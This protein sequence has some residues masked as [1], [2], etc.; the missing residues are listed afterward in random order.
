MTA[1]LSLTA[2]TA[3]CVFAIAGCDQD[4]DHQHT[5]TGSAHTQDTAE[6]SQAPTTEAFYEGQ[7]EPELI[8]APADHGHAHGDA[9]DGHEH[10]D[11]AA[12][13]HPH[14]D[15]SED[16]DDHGHEHGESGHDH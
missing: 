14:D 16:E 9:D 5:E 10:E 6:S 13:G 15:E 2:L 7:Q 4:A 11:A 1:R 8:E 12:H 3:L